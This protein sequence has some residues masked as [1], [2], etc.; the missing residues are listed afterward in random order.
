MRLSAIG[1]GIKSLSIRNK[2]QENQL[3]SLFRQ[4]R[5]RTPTIHAASGIV[6]SCS[7]VHI[8]S[9]GSGVARFGCSSAR[10]A[11]GSGGEGKFLLFL[12][13]ARSQSIADVKYLLARTIRTVYY[14][15]PPPLQFLNVGFGIVCTCVFNQSSRKA[16][17]TGS[18]SEALPH[19]SSRFSICH[20][21]LHSALTTC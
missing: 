5:C 7:Q 6:G 9:F 15:L 2:A 11:G 12:A 20:P 3:T 19:Q 21:P 18:K 1:G 13:S 4:N 17:Y 10:C 14:L 16:V 8:F